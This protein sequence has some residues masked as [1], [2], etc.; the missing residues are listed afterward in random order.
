MFR[1]I[2][3][4]GTIGVVFDVSGF[5]DVPRRVRRCLYIGMDTTSPDPTPT[6][7]RPLLVTVEQAGEML[8]VSRSSIDQLIWSEQLVPIRI[9]RSVRFTVEQVERFV[10]QRAAFS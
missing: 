4:E 6:A 7:A 8:A 9:G 10:A 1:T 2:A 5:A 3:A